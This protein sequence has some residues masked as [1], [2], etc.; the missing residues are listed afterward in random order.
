M[1]GALLAMFLAISSTRPDWWRRTAILGLAGAIGWAFG[2][3]S[4][5]GLLVGYTASDSFVD[6]LYGYC[7]FV[8]IG[9]MWGAIGAGLLGMAL[10]LPR[11][12]LNAFAGPLLAIGALWTVT[13]WT[14]VRAT[15]PSIH[16]TYWFEATS[17]LAIAALYGIVS[18][19][20]RAACEFILYIAGGW[21]LGLIVLVLVLGLQLNPPRSD[22]WAACMG[23]TVAVM[24][25]L[26]RTENRAALMLAR[27][28]LLAGGLGFL[29]GDF[30][31]ILQRSHWVIF[32]YAV[33]QEHGGWGKM[34]KL[35]GF[36]MGLGVAV[37][38]HRLAR[39]GLESPIEDGDQGYLN[40]FAVFFMFVPM[41]A[42]NFGQNIPRWE[43]ANVY[44]EQVLGVSGHAW[45]I[46][47]GALWVLL[48]LFALYRQRRH[49]LS[50]VPSSALGKGQAIFLVAQ[51]VIVGASFAGFLPNLASPS[52]A[53]SEVF[54]V[55]CASAASFAILVHPDDRAPKV[56]HQRGPSDLAWTPGWSYWGSWLLVPVLVASLAWF[57]V[58]IAPPTK[59]EKFYRFPKASDAISNRIR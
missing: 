52:V 26:W 17:A 43:K 58:S 24:I 56:R 13:E 9:A 35:F 31:Q 1:P 33:L 46:F 30:V 12:R 21:W 7:A 6:I 50:L 55:I 34:E 42:W 37:G 27:Y 8:L 28:G 38:V 32:E 41:M 40:E 44:P 59:N 54:Y 29:L 36:V 18:P 15:L 53:T 3:Q 14:G 45:A 48:L 47:C 49:G 23:V 4:S 57:S 16:D 19:K 11:S 5:Y 10:T 20:A 22:S 51:S 25:Y 39:E 2:G